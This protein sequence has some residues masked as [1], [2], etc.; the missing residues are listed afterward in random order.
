MQPEKL[1]LI[2][3]GVPKLV[4]CFDFTVYVRHSFHDCRDGINNFYR[5]AM[6]MIGSDVRW[7]YTEAMTHPKPI[8]PKA[9]EMVPTWFAAGARTR[10]TYQMTLRAGSNRDEIL[11]TRFHLEASETP[12]G[13]PPSDDPEISTGILRL[14]LPLEIAQNGAR[15]VEIFSK[16]LKD[17][18]YVSGHAGI[19]LV[20]E[21]NEMDPSVDGQIRTWAR[22]YPGLDVFAFLSYYNFILHGIK[23]VN[24]L[25]LINERSL[26]KLGGQKVIQRKLGAGIELHR[27]P[28]GV[29]VQAGR[30]PVLGDRNRDDDL[31][32]Y[33]RVGRALKSVRDQP[34]PGSLCAFVGDEEETMDWLARFDE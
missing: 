18:P 11:P 2:Q 10:S 32:S 29:I 1:K 22:K 26:S 12:R 33:Q 16:L 34:V 7:F 17:V 27:V 25:T 13:T 14:V 5:E 23:C 3:E 8:T 20:W 15:A 4:S 19:G 24:W 28:G 9:L 31:M 21:E 6:A 30:K